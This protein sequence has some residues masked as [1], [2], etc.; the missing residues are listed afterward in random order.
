MLKH[1]NE[2]SHFI[3]ISQTR[4]MPF[5]DIIKI[6]SSDTES[7]KT[8]L[9]DVCRTRWVE[10]IEGLD[11]FTEL[12]VPLYYTLEAMKTNSAGEYNPSLSS[13]ASSHLTR[14]LKF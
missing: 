11:T 2:V 4:N 5:E 7:R 10:R 8:K 1:V 9:G 13:D 14:I 6:H 12:F 3:N